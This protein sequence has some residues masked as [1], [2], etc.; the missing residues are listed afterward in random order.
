MAIDLQLRQ[1]YYAHMGSVNLNGVDYSWHKI[2]IVALDPPYKRRTIVDT[3][4][5]PRALA[6]DSTNG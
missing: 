5:K 1:L 3:A 4:D 6:L 2:E